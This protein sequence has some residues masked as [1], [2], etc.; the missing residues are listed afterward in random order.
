VACIEQATRHT[1]HQEHTS[2]IA[3]GAYGQLPYKTPENVVCMMY[4]IFSSLSLFVKGPKKHVKIRQLNKLLLDYGVDARAGCKTRTD[5]RFV[6]NK[7][8][9]FV[10]LLGNGQPTRGLYAHNTN[11]PKIK[12]DQRGG[13]CIAAMGQFASFATKTGIDS[14]GLGRWTCLYVGGG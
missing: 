1:V 3:N 9:R 10:N 14:F 11:N 5:W 2:I 13:A 4:E 7:E 12:R 6:T 8:N